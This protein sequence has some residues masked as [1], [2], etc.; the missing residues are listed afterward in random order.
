MKKN[1][2]YKLILL[3]LVAFI[4]MCISGAGTTGQVPAGFP[5]VMLEGEEDF[6][7]AILLQGDARG[8][9]GPCG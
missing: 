4:A 5:A 2:K 7:F 6:N 1:A 8:N 9:Y 3:L